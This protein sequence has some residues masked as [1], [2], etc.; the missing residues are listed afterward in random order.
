M[1]MNANFKV[2]QASAGAGKTFTLIKE[3]LKICLKSEATVGAYKGILAITFTNAAANEMKGKIVKEL[4]GIIKSPAHEPTDMEKALLNE[5][6]IS[7]DGLKRNA[8]LLLTRIIH[9]Y[10]NFCVSTIDA[11]VQ[12]LSRAFAHDL[13]LPN[14]YTVSIDNDEIA[15]AVVENIG[16]QIGKENE[17]LTRLLSDFSDNQFDQQHT[18]NLQVP[19][20]DFVKKLL[21]EK[22]YQREEK[23]NIATQVQYEQTLRYLQDKTRFFEDG[24]KRLVGKFK[25]LENRFGIGEADFSYGSN[26]FVGF[27]NKLAKGNYEPMSSRFMTVAEKGECFSAAGI[28]RFGNPATSE[29]NEALLP[30]LH[31]LRAFYDEE[32]GKYLFYKAQRDVLYLYALR[33]QIRLAFEQLT[34]DDEIVHISE[35][36]KLLSEVMGDFTVPFVYERIG[37]RFRHIFVDEF[38]DTSVMQWQN[39]LPLID[40]G[41]A[42]GQMS[43]VV[44]DGKQSIYRFRSG[45]VEQIVNLPNIYALPQDERKPAFEQFERNLKDNFGFENLDTNYRSFANVVKFNNVF[46]ESVYKEYLSPELQKVYVDKKPN[47]GQGVEV[48]QKNAKKEEGLVQ[49]E[50]YDAENEPDYCFERVEALV[51]DLTERYGYRYEDITVLTRKTK[52]GSDLANYLNELGI[53]VVSKVSILL[54]SSNK[55]QLMLSALN[56]LI[57]GDFQTNIANLLYYWQLNLNPDFKGDVSHWFDAVK[58][59]AAGSKSIETVMGIGESGLLSAVL[60]NATC[61]YDL[62]A[63]L[64]RVFHLDAV[65]DA[66]LNYFMDEVFRF[67]SGPKQGIEAFLTFWDAKKN[68]LAVKSVESNAVNIMTI[69]KSKGLEFPVVIYPDAIVNLD[70]RLQVSK[71]PEEWLRPEDLDFEPIPNV[72]K[73]MFKLDKTARNIGGKAAQYVE[74]EEESNRLDNLNLL[75]VAFTR[76]KQRLYVMAEQGQEGKPNVIRDFVNSDD[77]ELKF[78]T[79]EGENCKRYRLGNAG[80]MNP[81]SEKAEKLAVGLV[82]SQSADWLSKIKVESDPSRSWQSVG[83]RLKPREWGELVHQIL[84]KVRFDENLG[85]ILKPYLNNSTIDSHD[86]EWIGL[87][88]KQMAYHPLIGAAFDASAKVKTE[89]EILDNGQVMRLDRYSELPDAIY[90]IDYKTGAKSPEH[91]NQLQKYVAAV[92]KLGDKEIRAFLVYLAAD[93]IEV[94]QVSA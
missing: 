72:D 32:Y 71:A 6:G 43:L 47:S 70:K 35:F 12:K 36:N 31:D 14:Q 26:G 64:L 45:E 61:L 73:V 15:E 89:C 40:N 62:C 67:Q 74:K 56:Y 48:F 82:D 2:F 87:K 57:H 58:E 55:V 39:L 53:P 23:N 19:L 49:V 46:F 33:T 54:Q 51:R 5:L 20:G 92:K 21:T 66:F 8:Q 83:E 76:A 77:L 7:D 37:E 59:I 10:S 3:Y 90:L 65:R 17:F 84:S 75:Y 4:D 91:K 28:K 85:I 88:F 50:L 27:I 93:E 22:A 80:F 29:M 1:I 18:T 34:T 9:D 25:A 78:E 81:K 11:F 52:P 13:G 44:G 41:L 30:V 68:D 69:H 38:Q 24:V 86:A 79:E 16:Q 60:A 42:A 63:N 94:E